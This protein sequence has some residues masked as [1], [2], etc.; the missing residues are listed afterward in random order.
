METIK[1][2]LVGVAPLLMHS[3]RAVDPSD[4]YA[5]E[6]RKITDKNKKNRT[7]DDMIR[8]SNLEFMAGLHYD[9]KGY[10]IP[11]EAIEMMLA[12]KSNAVAKIGKNNSLAG[13][14]ALDN[15]YLVKFDGPK[16]PEERM[17]DRNCRDVR[18]VV[19][20]KNRIMRC[21]PVFKNWSAVGEIMFD[22]QFTRE[23][24]LAML[25]LSKISG[26]GDFRP[27]FGRFEYRVL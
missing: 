21:R 8:L 27:R 1:I 16:K 26:I 15:F 7:D 17:Q 13:V 11:G 23:K 4:E 9:E 20:V 14:F 24:I 22:K 12:S 6:I 5:L 2:E 3:S 25:D 10:F 19:V 18:S